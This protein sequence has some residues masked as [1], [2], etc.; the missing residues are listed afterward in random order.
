MLHMRRYIYK[1]I[2][3]MI[4]HMNLFSKQEENNCYP[5]SALGSYLNLLLDKLTTLPLRPVISATL[6]APPRASIKASSGAA[7]RFKLLASVI[8]LSLIRLQKPSSTNKGAI[9]LPSSS[10]DT[11][12]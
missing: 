2:Q 9:G 11:V 6:L 4:D 5:L 12:D 1:H 7:G 10:C 3:Y 8:K